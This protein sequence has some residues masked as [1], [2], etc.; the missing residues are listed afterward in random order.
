MVA[1]LK[2]PTK[3]VDFTKIVDFLKVTSLKY[4]LTHNPTIYDFLVK[5]F[6]QTATVITLANGIQELVASID[7]KEYTIIEASVRSKLQLADATWIHVPFVPV[8]LAGAAGGSDEGS[9]IQQDTEIPQSQGPTITPVADEAT[10]IGVGVK[11][12]GAATTTS[13]LDAGLDSRNIYESPIR[14]HDALSLIEETRRADHVTSLG[15]E[16]RCK[17]DK[18]DDGFKKADSIKEESKEEEG[19]RKRK[20]GT[21]KKIKSRK[22]RFRQDTSKGDNTD[23]EKENDELR[24]CLTIAL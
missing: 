1:F 19:T 9:A 8:M 3:S 12:E 6:W 17:F 21:R 7:N 4:A 16:K 15:E 14:S 20:L 10:T 2:K 5:H 23:S 11:T 18:K 13:G 24:L 22:R